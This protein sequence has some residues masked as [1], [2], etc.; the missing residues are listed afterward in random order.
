MKKYV[1]SVL[2][3]KSS[4]CLTALLAIPVLLSV[5]QGCTREETPKKVSLSSRAGE[6][7][8][9]VASP[10]PNTL[11][12]GFDLRLGPKEE[13]MIYTP[14]LQYL[15]TTTGKRFRIKFTESYEDTVENLGRGITQFASLDTL[16]YVTGASRYG[17][18][19]LVSGV[20]REGDPRYHSAIIAMPDSP[21]HD[22]A[23]LR[24]RCFAF[25]A[26]MST[27]GHLIP[28]KMLEDA[29]I[30]LEDLSSSR[31][32]GSH[33]NALKA[34]LNGE[35][36]AAG[37]QDTLATAFAS[38]GTVRI[39]KISGAY[40]SSIIAYN[41]SVDSNTVEAVRAALLAFDPRG[42]HRDLLFDWDRT[43]MPMGF[44][45]VEEPEFTR[46]AILARKYGL[47]TP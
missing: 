2:F 21:V 22:L 44:T 16:N 31:F 12:F 37:V 47:L 13:V 4:A 9:A 36:D 40:P 11:W 5:F 43:E 26:K 28:R 33:M 7:A 10:Q 25:G 41:S 24:G 18:R 1:S 38:E 39:V 29:G 8:E 14:F 15:E 27:Q 6:T 20:N 19:Y 34:V 32:T 17:V 35:C 42:K 45:R 30:T 46:V 23:D 3:T